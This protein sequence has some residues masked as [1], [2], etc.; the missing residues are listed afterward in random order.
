M[1]RGSTKL[2]LSHYR[3]EEQSKIIDKKYYYLQTR[4]T[5]SQING[6]TPA[7]KS[8]GRTFEDIYNKGI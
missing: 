7:E 4:E 3:T 5:L 2:N 6:N 1:Y 8:N